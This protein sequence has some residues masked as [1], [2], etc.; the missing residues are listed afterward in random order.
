MHG[1]AN[2]RAGL[3]KSGVAYL[4]R[5]LAPFSIANMRTVA[6]QPASSHL[7]EQFYREVL[8]PAWE[9]LAQEFEGLIAAGKL[10]SDDPWTLAMHWKGL[11]EADL[12][13]RR[14]IGVLH[15]PDRQ[16]L[17]Q[18]ATLAADAFLKIYGAEPKKSR[19]NP[20]STQADEAGEA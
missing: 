2:L 12:L 17:V 8:R 14:I 6:S 5:Q 20:R 10:R 16:E 4:E 15:E 1:A 7:G 19:L 11:N 3:V 9:R 13:E 18:A